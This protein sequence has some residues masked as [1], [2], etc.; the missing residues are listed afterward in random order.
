MRSAGESVNVD[1][2]AFAMYTHTHKHTPVERKALRH[3]RACTSNETI[4]STMGG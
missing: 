2:F 3:A 4:S 1:V